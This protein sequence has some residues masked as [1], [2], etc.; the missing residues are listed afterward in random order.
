[1]IARRTHII[2]LTTLFLALISPLPAAAAKKAA[3]RKV[4]TQ[5]A[6]L[7]FTTVSPEARLLVEKA[8][9]TYLDKV[10]QTEA[11]EMLRKAVSLDPNFAMGHELLAQ[12]S[13][14]SAEQVNEQARAFA[15]REHA[16]ALERETIEWYQDV[17]DHKLLS[18]ITTMNGLLAQVP[19]DKT[20]VWMITWWLMTQQQYDRSIA[21]YE[22]SGIK[23]SPGLLNNMAYAYAY[24]YG[25]H[26]DKAFELMDQY[27]A[28][29]PHDPNPQ[30]SYAEI[31]RMA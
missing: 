10:E 20:V 5:S 29:M 3:P 1:M 12:I 25:R 21:I 9:V 7:P 6:S 27:V 23:N 14:E 11:I 4:Q 28:A 13:L 31:L 2:F 15:T 30:D 16:S 18:A 17:S 8:I 19:H 22:H 26:F 24:A